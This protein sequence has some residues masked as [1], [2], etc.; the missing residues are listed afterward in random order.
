L[1]VLAGCAALLLEGTASAATR[2]VKIVVDYDD[3]ISKC[4][5]VDV[6]PM[7]LK[8]VDPGDRIMW[9]V[10]TAPQ[11]CKD[12]DVSLAKFKLKPSGTAKDPFPA[13]KKK[14]KTG[15]KDIDCTISNASPGDVF[16]YDVELAGG[17]GLDPEIQIR[18]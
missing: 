6:K 11:R 5:V 8:D 15:G 3:E 18:R 14:S 7:I 16:K 9:N 17:K 4:A 1:A 13:C 2:P 10:K 12:K